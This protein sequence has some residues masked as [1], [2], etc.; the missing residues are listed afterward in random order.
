MHIYKPGKKASKPYSYVDVF[1]DNT[2]YIIPET[3]YKYYENCFSEFF[4]GLQTQSIS[5]KVSDKI[6]IRFFDNENMIF[7][8]FYLYSEGTRNYIEILVNERDMVIENQIAQENLSK[9][10]NLSAITKDN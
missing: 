4:K 9:S 7:F 6:H 10:N 1:L 8:N 2:G 3:W 5:S